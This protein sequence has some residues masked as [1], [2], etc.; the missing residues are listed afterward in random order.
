VLKIVKKVYPPPQ[1]K[2]KNIPKAAGRSDKIP[3]I[4][5]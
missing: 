1:K 3:E 2:M 4:Y 5:P